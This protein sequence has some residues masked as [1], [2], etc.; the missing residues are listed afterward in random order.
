LTK[1]HEP[2]VVAEEEQVELLEICQDF[3]SNQIQIVWTIQH[4]KKLATT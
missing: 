4:I 2:K 1:H 3:V